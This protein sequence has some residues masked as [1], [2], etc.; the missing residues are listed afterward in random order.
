M[1]EAPL[2]PSIW[3]SDDDDDDVMTK[4]ADIS[5]AAQELPPSAPGGIACEQGPLHAHG[6]AMMRADMDDK[7]AARTTPTEKKNDPVWLLTQLLLPPRQRKTAETPASQL[8]RVTRRLSAGQGGL[9]SRWSTITE[10]VFQQVNA[11]HNL[12][13]HPLTYERTLPHS[14][15]GTALLHKIAHNPRMEILEQ[16]VA[17]LTRDAGRASKEAIIGCLARSNSKGKLSPSEVAAMTNASDR[18][19]RKARHTVALDG[20]LGALA[21]SKSGT[22]SLQQLCPSRAAI[23]G[24][25]EAGDA[26]KHLHECQCCTQRDTDRKDHS[27]SDCPEWSD[28]RCKKWNGRRLA[29]AMP[30]TRTCTITSETVATRDWMGTR[31]PARSGD[32]QAICWMTQGFS[33]FYH[34]EYRT[35]K[36]QVE[37]IENALK[38]EGATLREAAKTRRNTWLRNVSN[39]LGA[40]DDDTVDLLHVPAIRP[41][42][43][44]MDFAR[45]LNE[46]KETER[47]KNSRA[48][49]EKGQTEKRR[50]AMREDDDDGDD[51][52]DACP[53]LAEDSDDSDSDNDS[54]EEDDP[55]ET[56]VAQALDAAH[57]TYGHRQPGDRRDAHG[58]TDDNDMDD[59]HRADDE[60]RWD[61]EGEEDQAIGSNQDDDKMLLKP[62][63]CKC[64]YN[65]ILRGLR[66]W[67][68]PPHNHCER[69][70]LYTATQ[71]RIM[72]LNQAL[73]CSPNSP[74][75][76]TRLEVIEGA[77]GNT[78]AWAELYAQQHRLPDL[79]KHMDWQAD[80]RPYSISRERALTAREVMLYLDY[81]GFTD[82]ANKK[83]SVWSATVMAMGRLQE[84]FDFFFDQGGKGKDKDDTAKKNG[85][86]GIAML[87]ELFDPAKSPTNDGI[88]MFRHYYPH[89]DHIILSGD[90][91]NG[92]RA[93]AMLEEL[94][95]FFAKYGLKVTLM[96]LP[97]GHAWNRTDARI[98]HQNTFLEALK[99]ISNVRG[100]KEIAG[101]FHA[102]ADPKY[103]GTRKY[104]A[105]SHCFFRKVKHDPLG[106]AA[107]K[108]NIGEQLH[109]AAVDKGH[110]GVRGLLYFDFSVKGPN[111]DIIHPTGYARV[112]EFA[113]PER[114]NNPTWVYTWRKDLAA[115]MCQPCSDVYGGPV[116]KDT[117]G[118]SKKKCAVV[119]RNKRL[120]AEADAAR[121]QP[122][123]PLDRPQGAVDKDRAPPIPAKPA[124]DDHIRK[125]GRPQGPNKARESKRVCVPKDTAPLERRTSVL[126]QVRV[127]H[128]LVN[129]K[130]GTQRAQVWMYVA[131]EKN[132][133]SNQSRQGYWLDG[134]DQEQGLFAL[135]PEAYIQR[136]TGAKIKDVAV[137]EQFPFTRLIKLDKKN[138]REL[139]NTIRFITKRP[140]TQEELKVAM[141]DD[142][143]VADPTEVIANDDDDD[144]DDST[145]SEEDNEDDDDDDDGDDVDDVDDDD[146]NHDDHKADDSDGSPYK[147]RPSKQRGHGTP[148]KQVR[149][150]GRQRAK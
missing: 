101:A 48:D 84:H 144:N 133:K 12:I 58:M 135:R 62:R 3:S 113:N 59:T 7:R 99:D 121:V 149:R 118:C 142:P 131:T 11:M 74:G 98:A 124:G 78:K 139:K 37:I 88:S 22:R 111:G 70:G 110:M 96:P 63:S 107:I 75:Y 85:Q 103:M 92:Y 94:S 60:E 67:R 49:G 72:E 68:R 15:S 1:N 65:R 55:E 10:L 76:A 41:H 35:A 4:H 13:Y 47:K 38:I 36:G 16:A 146:K 28:K 87:E 115:K 143:D 109:S 120:A 114:K 80:Q 32:Q 119:E 122:Q 147:S 82:S 129:A 102:A 6:T 83:V 140:L 138:G 132:A 43:K 137:F 51:E 97:P 52:D 33:D 45:K 40:L 14:R 25:C 9:A 136:K 81:G 54:D 73:C 79:Q 8:R 95:T 108:K 148:P 89:Q 150:S 56:A 125:R 116:S 112:R 24:V 18:Y 20:N 127:V 21:H 106:Q 77:G 141:N 50:A 134:T 34:D 128:G 105:R 64:F 39:Y 19:I 5:D 61:D 117:N 17:D 53:P 26:C 42:N 130:G 57:E 71:A 100:A 104:M 69:C 31:C 30:V 123:L 91:G 66:L 44:V 93:Y 86:T 90:T 23:N 29:A 145:D 2:R 126:R 46:R 27:A